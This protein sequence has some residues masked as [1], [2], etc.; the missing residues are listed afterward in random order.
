[1]G[2]KQF[3][4]LAYYAQSPVFL[5]LLTLFAPISVVFSAFV[6]IDN[7]GGSTMQQVH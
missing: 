4:A 6:I 3:C 2:M 5:I 1:M 7:L